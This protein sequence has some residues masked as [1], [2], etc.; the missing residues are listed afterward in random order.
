MSFRV[1]ADAQAKQ[2][3]FKRKYDFPFPLA[4]EDKSVIEALVWGPKNLWE[5]NT[6]EFTELLLSSMKMELSMK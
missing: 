6:M 1:S 3:K 4:D 2:A 5:K